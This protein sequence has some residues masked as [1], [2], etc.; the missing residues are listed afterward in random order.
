[1]SLHLPIDFA[2]LR[3]FGL[4]SPLQRILH[5]VRSKSLPHSPHCIGTDAI[6]F[7]QLGIRPLLSKGTV[8]G[9]EQNVG[10]LQ[11]ASRCLACTN[12]SF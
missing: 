1:M 4:R 6:R 2:F 9:F 8:I 7:M 12:Q 11:T 5:A 10:M 3:A